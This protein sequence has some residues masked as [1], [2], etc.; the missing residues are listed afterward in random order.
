MFN[1]KRIWGEK[2]ILLKNF[3][4]MDWYER[5]VYMMKCLCDE[6]FMWW[7]VKWKEYICVFYFGIL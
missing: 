4:Y 3:I 6:M 7:K 2:N 1:V 5:N